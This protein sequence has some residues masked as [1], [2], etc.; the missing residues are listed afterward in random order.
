MR[1]HLIITYLVNIL[2]GK[3]SKTP[4]VVPPF[5]ILLSPFLKLVD[6][7]DVSRY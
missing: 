1:M 7:I 4:K 2:S 5:S 6:N 3:L